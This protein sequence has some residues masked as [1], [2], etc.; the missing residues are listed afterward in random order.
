MRSDLWTSVKD[1]GLAVELESYLE[2][3]EVIECAKNKADKYE[4]EIKALKERKMRID[5]IHK[6]LMG[7]VAKFPAQ[8]QLAP[9]V[10]STVYR[11]DAGSGYGEE[12]GNSNIFRVVKEEKEHSRVVEGEQAND[13]VFSVG[14]AETN[15]GEEPYKEHAAAPSRYAYAYAEDQSPQ[16]ETFGAASS[17]NSYDGGNQRNRKGIFGGRRGK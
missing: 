7:V 1:T 14:A 2:H 15:G 3:S 17:D 9:N 10:S 5:K 11:A 13:I 4:H 12:N 16:Q 6:D 8:R